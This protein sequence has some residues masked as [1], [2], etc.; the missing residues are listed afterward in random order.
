MYVLKIRYCSFLEK[1]LGTKQT[2][3]TVL[4]HLYFYKESDFPEVWRRR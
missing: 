4:W 3:V 1:I 2:L